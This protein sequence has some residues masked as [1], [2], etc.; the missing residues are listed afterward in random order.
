MRLSLLALGAASYVA[1]QNCNPTYNVASSGDCMKQCSM[2][3]GKSIYSDYT[4]DPA[5][6]NFIKSLSSSCYKGT[7]DYIAFMTSAGTCWLKCDKKQQDDYTQREFKESCSWYNEHKD[8][9]CN[10]SSASGSS[11]NSTASSSG[12]G[13]NASQSTSGSNH[14]KA[15]GIVAG[16][17]VGVSALLL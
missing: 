10:A 13:A 4:L 6:P 5:S 16:M 17:A 1:A 11:G 14:L 8:D 2:D 15:T 7:P 9:T 12:S 3:A